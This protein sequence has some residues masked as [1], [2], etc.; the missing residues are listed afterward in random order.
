M[1]VHI[2]EDDRVIG[3]GVPVR[4]SGSQRM[5]PPG[6]KMREEEKKERQLDDRRVIYSVSS[7]Y[8]FSSSSLSLSLRCTMHDA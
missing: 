3:G 8:L 7:I 4:S 6:E 2:A 5:G 1:P